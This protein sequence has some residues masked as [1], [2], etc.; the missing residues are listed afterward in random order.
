M[1]TLFFMWILWEILKL[2]LLILFWCL[3]FPI[4]VILLPFKL[5]K[6]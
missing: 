6:I 3:T 4:R 2:T 1:I 5:F